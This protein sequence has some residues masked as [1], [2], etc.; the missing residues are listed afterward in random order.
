M[1]VKLNDALKTRLF[2]PLSI[3][4]DKRNTLT[5]Y[6]FITLTLWVLPLKEFSFSFSYLK[7]IKEKQLRLLWSI[8]EIVVPRYATIA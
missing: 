4:N 5:F 3:L 1:G 8:C 7:P 6:V 2:A